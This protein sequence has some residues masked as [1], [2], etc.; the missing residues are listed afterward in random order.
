MQPI[1]GP[2]DLC[3]TG[4]GTRHRTA[5][6]FGGWRVKPW[7]R[8]NLFG[9]RTTFYII[10]QYEFDLIFLAEYNTLM[11]KAK[12]INPKI[13]PKNLEEKVDFIVDYIQTKLVTKDE[14]E[15]S[16]S[17]LAK[18]IDAKADKAD[19][20]RLTTQIDGLA[21]QIKDYHQEMIMFTR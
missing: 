4:D 10:Q 7:R 20:A 17:R 5:S 3:I 21:K 9:R 19:I 18:L 6:G 2:T 16:E 13:K 8:P 11:K 1:H 12:K 14:L 15:R